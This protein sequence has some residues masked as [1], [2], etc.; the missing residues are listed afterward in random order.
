VYATWFSHP[1]GISYYNELIG[2]YTG[3][4]DAQTMRQFWGYASRQALPWVNANVPKGARVAWHDT[5]SG[6]YEMYKREGLLRPDVGAT[7]DYQNADYLLF[8]VQRALNF[9]LEDAWS[10]YGTQAP[11]ETISIAGVP[12]ITVYPN[13]ARLGRT[14]DNRD[15][16]P[17]PEGDDGEQP[18]APAL[19]PP[20][21]ADSG[22]GEAG[23]G[24][25]AP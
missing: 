20:P 5:T 10:R 13:L 3:A 15:E 7:W 9:A 11:V 22:P 24:S 25:G 8:D 4:A 23:S 14:A 16:V 6:A 18:D 17:E 2:G 19:L 12:L 21:P 1:F